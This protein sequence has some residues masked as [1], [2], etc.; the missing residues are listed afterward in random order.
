[1]RPIH[2]FEIASAALFAY[3]AYDTNRRSCEARAD[4]ASLP[5]GPERRL[6]EGAAGSLET[7]AWINGT[8]AVGLFGLAA[9]SWDRPWARFGFLRAK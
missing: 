9:Y 7:D 1:M 8:L 4:A 6:V 2:V 3:R 5:A